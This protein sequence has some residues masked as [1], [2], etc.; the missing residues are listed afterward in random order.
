MS[1]G[2][3]FMQQEQSTPINLIQYKSDTIDRAL[4][5]VRCMA[6]QSLI[7]QANETAHNKIKRAD[8]LALIKGNA[9]IAS[10]TEKRFSFFKNHQLMLAR[11]AH[12]DSSKSN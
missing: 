3:S 11:S 7:I 4:L 10:D 12:N 1:S 8:I 9:I 5:L 2:A 6:C